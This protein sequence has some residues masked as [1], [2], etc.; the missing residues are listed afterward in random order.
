MD[1]RRVLITG[2]NRGLGRALAEHHLALGDRVVGCSRSESDLAHEHYTHVTMDVA[3]E[4]AVLRLFKDVRGSLGGLDALINNAGVASM[5]PIALTPLASARRVIDTNL[6]GTFLF[7]RSA[8]RLLRGAPAARI[9]NLTT[10]A[11]P[12]RLEG[13][14]VYAAT[15]SAIETFT[16][17]TAREVAPFG[18]TCN[19]VGPSPVKTALTERIPEDKIKALMA[20]QAINRWADACDVI[21]V[22]DFFLHPGSAMVTGQV[23]YLGG[24]G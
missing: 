3:D 10:I 12:M 11:V 18:I 16:R 4:A 20:R 21:N 15:K 5:N 19:A 13:E 24:N 1:G 2:A 22:V 8:V 23:I 9:V 14:A 17:I 7:T 6:L